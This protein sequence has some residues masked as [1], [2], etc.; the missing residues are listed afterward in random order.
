MSAAKENVF[1]AGII[2]LDVASI[3]AFK[4]KVLSA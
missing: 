2:I 4:V 3:I 1:L